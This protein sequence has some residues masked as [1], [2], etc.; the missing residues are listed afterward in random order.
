MMGLTI[1]IDSVEICITRLFFLLFG[2]YATPV[3]AEVVILYD[4]SGKGLFSVK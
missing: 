2:K 3:A 4:G 1:N